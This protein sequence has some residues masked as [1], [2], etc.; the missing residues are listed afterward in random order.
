M[1][2]F[3][4][5]AQN[6]TSPP[7]PLPLS[8]DDMYIFWFFAFIWVF[9]KKAFFANNANLLIGNSLLQK[10]ESNNLLLSNAILGVLRNE[11]LAI[12]N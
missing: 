3:S 9:L 12:W 7:L 4:L 8:L 10:T 1:G 2:S 5:S 11:I 6:G